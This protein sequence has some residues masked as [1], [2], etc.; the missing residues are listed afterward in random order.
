MNLLFCFSRKVQKG[1]RFFYNQTLLSCVATCLHIALHLQ[2]LYNVGVV[3]DCGLVAGSQSRLCQPSSVQQRE[4]RILWNNWTAALFFRVSHVP[5]TAH[6]TAVLHNFFFFVF[7]AQCCTSSRQA[8]AQQEV[9]KG[10][11]AQLKSDEVVE[12]I[13]QALCIYSLH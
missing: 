11:D 13:N 10:R 2:W 12:P 9:D 4:I 3:L 1:N 6:T 8:A 7:V 5:C